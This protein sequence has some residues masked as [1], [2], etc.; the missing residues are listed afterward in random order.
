[1]PSMPLIHVQDNDS[2][3]SGLLAPRYSSVGVCPVSTT[4]KGKV[5]LFATRDEQDFN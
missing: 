5:R 3:K 4:L 2:Q 1:M